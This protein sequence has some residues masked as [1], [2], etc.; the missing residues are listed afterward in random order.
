MVRLPDP[1]RTLDLFFGNGAPYEGMAD[2][3][4]PFNVNVALL[5]IGRGIFRR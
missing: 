1:F 4:R 5:P 3:L 2:R